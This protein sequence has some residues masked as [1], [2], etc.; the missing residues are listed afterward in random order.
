MWYHYCERYPSVPN[1]ARLLH[2]T[3]SSRDLD[4]PHCVLT[5]LLLL[6]LCAGPVLAEPRL[7]Q[8]DP[9]SKDGAPSAFLEPLLGD[10]TIF[11]DRPSF[12]AAFP[13]LP[14]EDF[15][16]GAVG[17]GELATCGAPLDETGDGTCFQAGDL[18]AG[19]VF[20]DDPGPDGIDGL[21][22]VGDGFFGNNTRILS[23]NTLTDSLVIDFPDPVEAVG[24]D[25][26]NLPGPPDALTVEVFAPG[27]VLLG[28]VST[29]SSATGEFWGVSS[30]SPISRL[31]LTSTVNDAEAIDNLAFGVAPFLSFDGQSSL[32]TCAGMP[33]NENG[34][35]EPNEEIE[36]T[37]DLRATGGDFTNI[38]GALT[39]ADPSIVLLQAE[40]SWPDLGVDQS[41]ASLTPLRFIID[42][43]LC[44]QIVELTLTVTSDQETFVLPLSDRVGAD[45]MPTVPL[46][47]PDG[48]P[49][50]SSSL[51]IS[52]D[53]ILDGLEVEIE[54]AHTWV[55][56]LTLTL[57][58]PASTEVVLLDRPGV[59]ADLLGCDNNDVRVTFSDA[60]AIDPETFCSPSSSDPWVTG[61][62]LPAEALSAF[63][64]ESSQGTWVL[65]VR[66]DV[67]GDLGTLLDW[68][69]VH[70]EPLGAE[71]EACGQQSDLSLTK[72]CTSFPFRC[73]LDVTN[74]GASTAFGVEVT[75]TIPPPLIWVA[76]DC[77]A[78][79]PVGGVLTW[80]L[81]SLDAG[82][83]ALCSIDFTVPE[84]QNETVL[85]VA[86]VTSQVPD[87]ELSNNTASD[88]IDL[89]TILDVPTL[90][91]WGLLGLG[92][93]LAAFSLGRLR[94]RR[95]EE[96]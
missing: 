70:D 21:L 44:A 54:I 4:S 36:L 15:E 45:Q 2:L 7:D 85:N 51:E 11:L 19:L 16:A 56:D 26:I 46:A 20:Q 72:T 14:V 6:G 8:G 65:S 39:T 63:D 84:N 93:A 35:W 57:T 87:P 71:C 82:E 13:G 79:P 69:L 37:V 5:G 48:L 33:A 1:Q 89:G 28:M 68:R 76:D 32:D 3:N 40:T 50:D 59:P 75:D 88:E 92:V 83:S 23:T 18:E 49:A 34:I 91:G 62:V 12:D 29:P 96:M 77:G 64:G 94:R 55:G 17:P 22:L 66:D 74:L 41:A 47:I 31:R 73:I 80:Q 10:L 67:S 30:P 58:S 60:A 78:G 52:T 9:A 95:I 42:G 27:D 86:T 61:L 90:S 43:D 24:L 38:A 81:A 25:L 53:V